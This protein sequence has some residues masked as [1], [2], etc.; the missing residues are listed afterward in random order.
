MDRR[1][2]LHN[3][4]YYR[5]LSF[6]SISVQNSGRC[7]TIRDRWTANWNPL[8][9][10]S[11]KLRV[12][13]IHFSHISFLGITSTYPLP[14]DM[15][16][17]PPKITRSYRSRSFFS[18]CVFKSACG[19]NINMGQAAR[20]RKRLQNLVTTYS[21][22]SESIS[23]NIP[24]SPLFLNLTILISVLTR[25]PLIIPRWYEIIFLEKSKCKALTVWG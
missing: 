14:D 25:N 19:E 3:Y 12:I 6:H 21:I 23:R 5:S 8:S 2:Q 18:C 17:F 7:T 10:K 15:I 22:L 24:F 1:T 20:E 13:L 9:P 4:I 16:L 11:M